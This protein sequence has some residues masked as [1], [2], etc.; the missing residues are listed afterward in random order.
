LHCDPRPSKF[1]GMEDQTTRQPAAVS[2]DLHRQYKISVAREGLDDLADFFGSRGK[3]EDVMRP[4][5][6]VT[7]AHLGSCAAWLLQLL[8]EKR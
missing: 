4:L 5:G 2:D 8:E 7:I 3:Y 6:A 1:I